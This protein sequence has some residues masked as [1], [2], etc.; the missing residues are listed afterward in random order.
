MQEFSSASSTARIDA[1]V[2]AGTFESQLE[3]SAA[4]IVGSAYVD[5]DAAELAVGSRVELGSDHSIRGL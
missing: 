3:T 2:D 4:I 5:T 1:I